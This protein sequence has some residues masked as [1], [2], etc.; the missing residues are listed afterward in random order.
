VNFL[1]S[2]SAGATILLF[3][4][5]FEVNLGCSKAGTKK[6]NAHKKDRGILQCRNLS[7]SWI[8]FE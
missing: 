3:S 2:L 7:F 1:A 8:V 6:I 5:Q 4:G